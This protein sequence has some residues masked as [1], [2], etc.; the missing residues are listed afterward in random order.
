MAVHGWNLHTLCQNTKLLKVVRCPFTTET[1]NG[2]SSSCFFPSAAEV[3]ATCFG[4][5]PTPI[6]QA[7][8]CLSCILTRS[9]ADESSRQMGNAWQCI[10]RGISARVQP[11]FIC[12][13]TLRTSNGV[14]MRR[15]THLEHRKNQESDVLNVEHPKTPHLE[16]QHISTHKTCILT[17]ENVV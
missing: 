7:P 9:E 17:K 12:R 14:Q 1:V 11:N 4:V 3:P 6:V 10:V 5:A 15:H 13:H 8:S 2:A 16:H